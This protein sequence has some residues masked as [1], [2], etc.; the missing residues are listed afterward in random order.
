M[1]VPTRMSRRD[2][3]TVALVLVTVALFVVCAYLAV[4]NF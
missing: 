4:T 1:K 3:A 2:A